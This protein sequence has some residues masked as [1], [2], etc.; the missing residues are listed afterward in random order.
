MTINVRVSDLLADR[1]ASYWLKSAVA[2]CM[3]RDPVD[4]LND[5]EYLRILMASR[6]AEIEKGAELL[7]HQ[8]GGAK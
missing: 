4:A 2:E 8:Q 6:L 1:T 3:R 7:A 5:A